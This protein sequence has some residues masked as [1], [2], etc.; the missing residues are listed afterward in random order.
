MSPPNSKLKQPKGRKFASSVKACGYSG[1]TRTTNKPT[2]EIIGGLKTRAHS[3]D[4]AG[5]N[6]VKTQMTPDDIRQRLFAIFPAFQL[7]W[8]RDDEFR[9]EDGFT[10]YAVFSML[11]F[12]FEGS[13][14]Q[15]PIS[16]FREL[17]AFLQEC[18]AEGNGELSA[19]VTHFL[20]FVSDEAF[21]VLK[22]FLSG[23]GSTLSARDNPGK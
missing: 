7:Y 22:V 5:L 1:Q 2:T 17:A 4:R 20:E 8:E 12:F 18:A 10:Y 11:R 6:R 3:Q 23:G 21:S 19:A 9:G 16:S 14:D 15:L 13:F